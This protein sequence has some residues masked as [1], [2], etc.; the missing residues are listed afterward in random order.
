MKRSN[1]RLNTIQP[2]HFIYFGNDGYY[3]CPIINARFGDEEFLCDLK[4]E[5]TK[6]RREEEPEEENYNYA[7]RIK[8]IVES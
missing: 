5:P 4:N 2:N 1:K 7:M 6:Y 8:R 3:P